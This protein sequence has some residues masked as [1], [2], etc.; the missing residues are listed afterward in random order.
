MHDTPCSGLDECE[1]DLSM[2]SKLML[3]GTLS[4]GVVWNSWEP[5]WNTILGSKIPVLE[6]LWSSCKTPHH[7]ASEE[8]KEAICQVE[9]P[10]SIVWL[11]RAL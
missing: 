10:V 6:L 3:E 2:L 7:P 11:D 1:K 9:V 5:F 8:Y 4:M